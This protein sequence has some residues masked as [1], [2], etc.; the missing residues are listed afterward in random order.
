MAESPD[1]V[2]PTFKKPKDLQGA[3]HA[4]DDDLDLF[5]LLGED[6]EQQIIM[7]STATAPKRATSLP[8]ERIGAPAKSNSFSSSSSTS[9]RVSRRGSVS[10][11]ASTASTASSSS[12]SSRSSLKKS[13][14]DRS[15]SAQVS[16]LE[17]QINSLSM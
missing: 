12:R 11:V 1:R 4:S 9:R 8:T 14:K 10:T 15:H 13:K 3:F 2:A 7:S 5:E 17:Q 6:E 16:L